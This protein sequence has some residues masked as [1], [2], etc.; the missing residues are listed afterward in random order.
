MQTS[1]GLKTIHRWIEHLFDMLVQ[2]VKSELLSTASRYGYD[3][4]KPNREPSDKWE[5]HMNKVH[6]SKVSPVV[7]SLR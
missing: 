2:N 7:N 6:S 3:R 4:I 5:V 1:I